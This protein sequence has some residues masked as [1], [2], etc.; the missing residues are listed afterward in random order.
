MAQTSLVITNYKQGILSFCIEENR[1]QTISFQ[2]HHADAKIGDIF[3]AKVQNV[4]TSINAAF[5]LY[6]TGKKG[7]LALDSSQNPILLNRKY[8]GRILA[9][10][11]VLVQM[12]KEAIRSKEPVF[13]MN[14]SLSG[15]Y[16]VVTNGNTKLG[17]SNKIP[18]KCK[19]TLLEAIPD[20]IP[21]GVVVR[22]NAKELLEQE[23]FVKLTEEC[24]QLTEQMDKLLEAGI[25]RTCFSKVYDAWDDFLI[26][27]RDEYTC[28]YD[29]IVTD[30]EVLFEKTKRFM[31]L[32][33]PEK[34][35]QLS[36]YTDS[37]S[38]HKL[39]SIETKLEELLQE[40]V[41]LKSGAYLVI[42][43]TEAMYV[44]DVNSGKKISKKNSDD[45]ILE[46][47]LEAAREIMRQLML[48]NLSGIIIV[49]F[50]NMENSQYVERLLQELRN[51]ALKDKVKTTVVDITPL[52]LI[53]ITRQKTKK[54]LKNQFEY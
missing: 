50:I 3:V 10:D 17:V 1:I 31:E 46:I 49:D 48:R 24:Q 19:E 30:D 20:G 34:L 35:S 4:V 5:I 9:G 23:Q 40:K 43:Q 42:E 22:T 45:N 47:N 36:F 29:K 52:G 33:M 51:L 26:E 14:L 13:T 21:Y 6:Q 37:Y 8:D 27:L 25:H 15:K 16:C 44:I 12:E 54:S 11:E 41:W 2:N 18:K 7:F 32:Y 28:T 39:Y 53:E 38:L